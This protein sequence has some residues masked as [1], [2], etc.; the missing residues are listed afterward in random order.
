M[1]KMKELLKEHTINKRCYKYIGSLLSNIE[2]K[3]TIQ[4]SLSL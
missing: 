4:K 1:G 2:K 3:K